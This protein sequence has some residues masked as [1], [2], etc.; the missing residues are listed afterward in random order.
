MIGK[1]IIGKSFG[2]CVKYVMNKDTAELLDSQWVRTE[3]AKLATADFNAI[4]QQ[5][6]KLKKAVWHATLSFAYPDKVD[7]QLMLQ[8]AKE[9]IDKLGLSSTQ[10]LIV[11]HRDT[12]H[13]HLHIVANRVQPNGN[14][15]SDSYCKNRSAKACN[16]LEEKYQLVVARHQKRKFISNDKIPPIRKAKQEIHLAILHCL[17]RGIKNLAQLHLALLEHGIEM[18]IQEQSTGR[19]N[20]ISFSKDG[21]SIKGSSIDKSL[22]YGRLVKRFIPG[23]HELS[24]TVSKSKPQQHN[25]QDLL[26]EVQNLF[27]RDAKQAEAEIKYKYD[28]NLGNGL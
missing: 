13:Q 14:V 20:G 11:R 24:R 22:S 16:E 15:V 25:G 4:R 6:T 5:N 27:N 9:F 8:I 7:N 1:A 28:N 26:N 10:Y 23:D 17:D 18:R 2:G 12:D 3:N 21:I 19:V